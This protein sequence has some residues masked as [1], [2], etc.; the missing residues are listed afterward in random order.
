MPGQSFF[1]SKGDKNRV[2]KKKIQVL[3]NNNKGQ[4]IVPV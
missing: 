1:V 4:D 2:V 3:K